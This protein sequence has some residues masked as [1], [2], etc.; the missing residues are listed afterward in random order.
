MTSII[1]ILWIYCFIQLFLVEPVHYIWLIIPEY[2]LPQQKSI[3]EPV[4]LEGIHSSGRCMAR[5]GSKNVYF[6][7]GIPGETVSFTLERRKHG[8]YS[9]K[10]EEVIVS[11]PYRAL[12]FCR[13]Y[14]ACGGCPWQHIHY[15]YQLEF[16]HMILRNALDKYGI[17]TPPVPQVIPSPET[18]G[19]RHRVEYTFSS[20]AY[21][22]DEGRYSGQPG[23][24]FHMN[25]EPSRVIAIREC[26]LQVEPSRAICAFTDKFARESGM[27]YY[28]HEKKS[29]FLR[30]LSV[31]I[32]RE[33]EVLVL[34]GLA[35][36]REPQR[37]D[38]LS[39][40]REEFPGISSL[41]YTVHESPRHGQLQGPIIPDKD[42]LPYLYE[43]VGGLTFR[44]HASAFFQPN[45]AQTEKILYMAREWAGDCD[46]IYDLYT[47]VG[48]IALILSQ[49]AGE[50]I[51]I[52]GSSSAIS[53]ALENARLNGI[54]NA[55]FLTGD[56]LETFK[57]QFLEAYGKPGLIVLDPP[58]S[59]TLIEIK[60]TINA[61][62]ARKVL[63][64]SCNPVS[65]A[66]DLKQLTEAYRVVRIQPFD[67]LPHTYQTETLVLLEKI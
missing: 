2:K 63:Y 34:V 52:E 29:G 6:E 58:R 21:D 38:L 12:P 41:N 26:S 66:F 36:D 60:K 39:R 31:R 24:G 35:E 42:S 33:G 37:N 15:S 13:H 18:T 5:Y 48:V 14:K 7:G 28:D 49:G 8:F 27:E 30:S 65:L 4:L 51:G 61:S 53:D 11:S 67:M 23:L 50:V 43:K 47:G 56:I 40:I 19:Y 46:R 20:N 10:I 44:I 45:I 9:G 16:K 1:L 22:E 32:N 25:G 59:G 17:D 3:R 62:G 57:P 64:L 54:K 55:R